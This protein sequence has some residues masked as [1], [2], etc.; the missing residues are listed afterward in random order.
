MVWDSKQPLK[1]A[2]FAL[3][4]ELMHHNGQIATQRYKEANQPKRLRD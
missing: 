3:L 2:V 4:G 1:K